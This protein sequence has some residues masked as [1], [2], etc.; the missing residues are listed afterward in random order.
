MDLPTNLRT[1][2][3]SATGAVGASTGISA[4]CPGGINA[5]RL[6]SATVTGGPSGGC[7]LNK[8]LVSASFGTV[9]SP[10][11]FVDFGAEYAYGH[12]MVLSGQKG[13]TSA[14]VGRFTVRF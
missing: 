13:D 11:S 14:V 8:E 3:V 2:P 10:V 12:R 5:T 4:V 6:G 9:W 1:I 7:T